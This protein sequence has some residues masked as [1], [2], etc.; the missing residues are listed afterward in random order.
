MP[1]NRPT[2]T[3]L[4]AKNRTQLQAELKKTGAL[5][6]YSN[7]RVLADADAGLAHLHYGYLDYIALQST[8]FN[9]TDEWLSGWAGLKSVYQNPANPA[10]TPSYEF[11]GTAGT[12]VNKG[13][14]LRRG[15]GY[16][17]RLEEN[18]TIG[19]NGKGVGK[20]TAILPDIID[21]PTGG[22]IDGNA[23]AGT[24]LTL[25]VSLPGIDASG[26]MLEPAT[27]GADIETQESFRARMLLA[28]QKPP[29]GGSDTD[30]EQW[31]LAVPGVT[32]CWVKRRLMGAGTVGVYI[33]CDGNDETNH[34]FPVGSDGISQLD[35]WGAQKAT[36]DQGRVADYIYPRAPV[37]A[38]VYVC[39][40]VA[41][42]V[43]FE[44]SGISHVGRD[45]TAAIA[46][47][48]DNVFF[49]GGTPVGN[50]RIFLSDLN[51][52]IRD[53]EGTA[54]F[55]LVSPSTNIDLGVGELPV[56]GEV[57]YT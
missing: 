28:Y 16:L 5:L 25:D 45:I 15:D 53:I 18:V 7:M 9:A 17:Y 26:V 22:G 46:A 29:Q 32:R 40:P 14:V 56:R 49:E 11:S 41:K 55:I 1:F 39:S 35:D 57:K 44:I 8:P 3:E 42:T 52:A 38:L 50:G 47:A 13:A 4:R 51:R 12:P 10:S 37:T 54:G 21:A 34:G 48:I 27:G 20:L 31:A 24:T 19:G 36:G 30:Y 6:R 23:D 33:M 43:D 2:L